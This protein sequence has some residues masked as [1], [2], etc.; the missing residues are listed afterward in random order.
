VQIVIDATGAVESAKL[1]GSRIGS[2]DY[3]WVAAAKAWRFQPA[4]RDGRPVRFLASIPIPDDS[5]LR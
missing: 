2:R 5:G 4:T 1:V 3:W